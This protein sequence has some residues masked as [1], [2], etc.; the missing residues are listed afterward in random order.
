MKLLTMTS[1]GLLVLIALL[2]IPS[3]SVTKASDQSP[4]P[5]TGGPEETAYQKLAE[6]AAKSGRSA[7]DQ[8]IEDLEKL[9]NRCGNLTKLGR[10]IE[11]TLNDAKARREKL[12]KSHKR[13]KSAGKRMKSEYEKRCP[14]ELC[15]LVP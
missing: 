10:S 12:K 6:K 5:C 3:T 14:D 9:S 2:W 15:P 7:L 13:V 8:V 4:G 1:A 11:N